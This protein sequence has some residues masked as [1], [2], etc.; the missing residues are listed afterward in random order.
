MKIPYPVSSYAL[1]EMLGATLV[2]SAADLNADRWRI[3]FC[4]STLNR[5]HQWEYQSLPS[6]RSEDYIARTRFTLAEALKIWREHIEW[7]HE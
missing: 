2:H 6:N 4:G 5:N 7:K 1:T 3:E